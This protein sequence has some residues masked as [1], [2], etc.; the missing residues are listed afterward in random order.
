M[1]TVRLGKTGLEVSRIGMGGIPIV[2]PKDEA[3]KVIRR[4]LDLGVTFIDT[5]WRYGTSKE[6]IGKAVAGVEAR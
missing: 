4:C 2:R 5:A 3:I 6:R 1:K